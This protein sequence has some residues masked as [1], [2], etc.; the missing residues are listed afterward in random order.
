VQQYGVNAPGLIYPFFAVVSLMGM[1][2]STDIYRCGGIDDPDDNYD[3]VFQLADV[4]E[5]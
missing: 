2:L 4:K 1:L 5:I 3:S